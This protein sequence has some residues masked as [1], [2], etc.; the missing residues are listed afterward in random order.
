MAKGM[1]INFRLSP[2][3]SA[4]NSPTLFN[5]KIEAGVSFSIKTKYQK[6]TFE[7]KK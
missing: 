5:Q 1:S 6:K 4:A 7:T 3:F 2:K